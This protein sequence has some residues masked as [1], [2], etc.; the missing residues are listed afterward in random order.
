MCMSLSARRVTIAVVAVTIGL[1][2]VAAQNAAARYAGLALLAIA[3]PFAALLI[4]DLKRLG[5]ALLVLDCGLQIDTYLGYDL[6]DA[7]FGATSGYLI[8]MSTVLI[9]AFLAARVLSARAAQLNDGALAPAITQR[10][11]VILLLLMALYWC[12]GAATIITAPN[13]ERVG[14]E[15]WSLAQVIVTVWLI[16]DAIRTRADWRF[17]VQVMIAGLLLQGVIMIA[18]RANGSSVSLGVING[19]VDVTDNLRVGG[20]LGSANAAASFLAMSMLICLSA[21]FATKRWAYKLL[22]AVALALGLVAIV[23][24]LSRGGWLSL[25]AGLLVFLAVGLARRLIK[26]APLLLAGALLA[27]LLAPFSARILERVTNDDQGNALARVR[28]NEL[29]LEMIADSPLIGT[30][31]NN[32]DVAMQ[33]YLTPDYGGIWLYT[34]HNRYLLIW[35]EM[36]LVGLAAF[37]GIFVVALYH[38][39][40]AVRHSDAPLA[41]ICLGLCA[42]LVVI[43]VHMGAD[44]FNSRGTTTL[45]WLIAI[46]LV[47]ARLPH[48]EIPAKALSLAHK[49]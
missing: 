43:L 28:L 12:I 8:S 33:S 4:P 15:L 14:Y 31:L 5:L 1:A 19:T 6:F 22:A 36:G 25:C 41:K 17:V 18:L 47:T 29:A 27:G 21:F 46:L 30:G 20:T 42:S 49:K 32:F 3:L 11:D 44:V 10:P 7:R 48:H 9:V 40:R 13:A 24:T 34:V 38:G 39:W 16:R 45:V 37:L 23:F 2:V 35:S 26:P